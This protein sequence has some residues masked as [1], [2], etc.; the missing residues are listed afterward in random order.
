MKTLKESML[1]LL[2]EMQTDPVNQTETNQHGVNSARATLL[3]NISE[4]DA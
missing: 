4:Q 1:E 2:N 3:G